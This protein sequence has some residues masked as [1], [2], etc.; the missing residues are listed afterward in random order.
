MTFLPQVHPGQRWPRAPRFQGRSETLAL[1]GIR[2]SRPA[3]LAGMML[4]LILEPL[5]TSFDL[6]AT[7]EGSAWRGQA[8]DPQPSH[9]PP[10][11]IKLR[12]S[13]RRFGP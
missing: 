7:R 12:G 6:E 4:E 8:L 5:Q 9:S 10:I 11:Q 13:R 1:S 2:I 3:L